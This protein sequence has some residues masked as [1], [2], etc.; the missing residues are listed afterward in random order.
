MDKILIADLQFHA[1][2]GVSAE[3]R[4][5]GQRYSIDVELA[6]DLASA[7]RTD[8]LAQT[9][10][11]AAVTRAVLDVGLERS[12]ALTEALAEAIAQAILKQFP[13]DEVLVRAKKLHP[14][15]AG[16]RGYFGVEIRRHREPG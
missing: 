11:Y 6:C 16:I 10:D 7:G 15:V 1:H 13:V 5:A 8:D 2:T 4:K 14:P 9:I 12:F 3:E